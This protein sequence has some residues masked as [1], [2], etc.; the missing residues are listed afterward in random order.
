MSWLVG[1]RARHGCAA[2]ILLYDLHWWFTPLA[3]AP[4]WAPGVALA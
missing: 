2:G 1:G 3:A 4:A